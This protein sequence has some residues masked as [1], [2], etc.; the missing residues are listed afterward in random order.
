MLVPLGRD[1][2]QISR[3]GHAPGAVNISQKFERRLWLLRRKRLVSRLLSAAS[4]ALWV[5][6]FVS[7]LF[8]AGAFVSQLR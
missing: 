6:C 1:K 2:A 3:I 5:S 8:V 7:L 4:L